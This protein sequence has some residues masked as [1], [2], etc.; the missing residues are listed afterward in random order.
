MAEH[1]I[2]PNSKFCQI[3]V[4]ISKNRGHRT[5]TEHRQPLAFCHLFSVLCPLYFPYTYKTYFVNSLP[6][7]TVEP[8]SK[9]WIRVQGKAS[10]ELKTER[11]RST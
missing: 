3:M 9:M 2:A 10:R 11:T 6:G 8:I 5:E 4:Q 7:V 1:L